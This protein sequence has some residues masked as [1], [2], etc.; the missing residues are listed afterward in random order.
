MPLAFHVIICI[1][2][3]SFSEFEHDCVLIK[4]F[5]RFNKDVCDSV[6]KFYNMEIFLFVEALA[7]L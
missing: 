4:L 3:G 2:Y 5:S 6:H 7:E 1:S